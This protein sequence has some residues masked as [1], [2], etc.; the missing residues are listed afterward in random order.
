M[1]RSDAALGVVFL[2]EK[3]ATGRSI[4]AQEHISALKL[5]RDR[6]AERVAKLTDE[7]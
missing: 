1:W 2:Q 4:R 3:G 5:E 7:F 6:L